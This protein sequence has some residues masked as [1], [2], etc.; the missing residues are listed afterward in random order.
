M[1][2]ISILVPTGAHLGCIDGTLQVLTEVNT[3]LAS[4][5]RP[6]AFTIQLTGLSKET[7]LK[8]GLFTVYPDVLISDLKKT[9]LI[10]I[11]APFHLDFNKTI[12]MNRD[13]LPWIVSQYKAGAEVASLCVGAF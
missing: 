4:K 2:H 8:N 3:Y 9:D 11:P 5:G 10:I 7:P 12:E 13:F 1:K 6:P